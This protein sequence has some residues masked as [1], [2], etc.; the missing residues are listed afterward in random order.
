MNSIR[1]GIIGCGKTT[2]NILK[3]FKFTKNIKIISFCDNQ[4]YK[5]KNLQEKN[6]STSIYKNYM[7]MIKNEK[8][9]A[10]YVSIPHF[11]HYSVTKNILKNNI[12]VFLEPPIATDV[13]QAKDL[14][15]IANA[16]NVKLMIN[17]QYRYNKALYQFVKCIKN[18][19]L[20]IIYFAKC[21]V[22]FGED[23]AYFDKAKWRASLEMAGGGTLI[24]QGAH[25]LD[26]LL[27]AF[28]SDIK[29]IS[30]FSKKLHYSNLEVEDFSTFILE[31]QDNSNLQFTST[32][33]VNLNDNTT[34]TIYGEKGIIKYEQNKP[35]KYFNVKCKKYKLD[36]KGFNDLHR[37][38]KGFRNLLLNNNTYLGSLDD[39][40][41][42][43]DT[44]IDVYNKTL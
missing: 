16:H 32:S 4:I 21:T 24:T 44:I 25:F 43:L 6:K 11:L 15:S 34:I 2:R 33:I 40:I 29:T 42:V 10:I 35:L 37:S 8:L 3:Y 39:S 26:I 18:N 20:G 5:A 17:Y 28:N 22:A 19:Q 7:D 13:D 36:V 1:L 38:I 41:K 14:F 9:D 31:F 12:H 23:Q 30:G 27:M